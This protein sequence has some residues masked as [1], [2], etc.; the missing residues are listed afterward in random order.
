VLVYRIIQWRYKE[1][2]DK[3]RRWR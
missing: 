2:D 3:K 1:D